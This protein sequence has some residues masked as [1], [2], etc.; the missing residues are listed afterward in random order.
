MRSAAHEVFALEEFPILTAHFKHKLDA[1]LPCVGTKC[2]VR[3]GN[4]ISTRA[5][6]EK[7]WPLIEKKLYGDHGED[8]K[9]DEWTDLFVAAHARGVLILL[10]RNCMQWLTKHNG[11][12]PP[13]KW[14]DEME[15]ALSG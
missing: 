7:T 11:R 10:D 8:E 15:E 1:T 6:R 4:K 12:Y 9:Y 2:T 14:T 13:A 3:R 5:K